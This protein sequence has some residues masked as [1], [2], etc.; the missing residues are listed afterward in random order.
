MSRAFDSLLIANRGEIACR[1]IAAAR[2]R[3]LRTIAVYS[4]ADAQAR[5]VAMADE[6]VRIGPAAAALSYLS[7]D[8]LLSAARTSGA[9]AVHPGYGFL[10]ENA[11][12]AG[13]CEAGG[14]VFVGPSAS[15]IAAMGNKAAAKRLMLDAGV[16]CVPGYQ[17]AAQD[18]ATL[19]GKAHRIGFP[20]MVK[21]AAGGGGRGMRLVGAADGLA[22]AIASARSEA[23]A[24]FGSAELILERAIVGA[25]HVE[26]QVMADLAG[27]TIHLGERDCSLQ[28]RHQKV[29]EEAPSPA[30]NAA[31]R[32]RM[33]EAATA[34]A[35]AIRYVGAG[36]VEFLLGDDNDFYFLEMNTRIQVEHPVTEMVTG[37]DLVGMQIDIAMGK[38]LG[39]DQGDVV[40]DGHAIEARLYAEDPASGF[41]PQTGR[42][43][44]WYPPEGE[45]VRTDHGLLPGAIVGA[46]YDPMLA[47]IV[48]HGRDREEACA[49]LIVALKAT[50]LLGVQT[51]KGFLI[52]CLEHPI[53]AAGEVTTDFLE[54][55]GS[56]LAALPDRREALAAAAVLLASG[57]RSD[58]LAGWSSTGMQRSLMTLR[59]GERDLAVAVSRRGESW[60]IEAGGERDELDG[61]RVSGEE[62]TLVRGGRAL[63]F[64]TASDGDVVHVDDGRHVHRFEDLTYR[65]AERDEVARDG[66]VRAPMNGRI[67]AV[68]VE[69]GDAVV[70]DTVLVV[71]EAMKMEQ[72]LR[73]GFDGVVDTVSV[74]V[75]EQV[76]TRQMLVTLIPAGSGAVS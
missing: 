49:R 62:V 75:G 70:K 38:P 8:A 23:L 1:V 21:A 74:S 45:G 47:K 41:L 13:A 15:A 10:S 25:R 40:L 29:I 11:A 4:D 18:D 36:T 60:T 19:T 20:L 26:I 17:G 9:Q 64:A 55:E 42:I 5:H 12:F 57:G 69:A 44:D 46:D 2:T 7:M 56:A 28:R 43:F 24:A 3:G 52:D 61:A 50:R 51:N 59:N 67:T 30:V 63:R 68:H 65:P 32:E 53:F 33:G 6:A 73:A 39:L 48:A 54:G 34:A 72:S 66:A 14:L 31:I 76:A 35:R 37:L 22:D 16:P 58:E 71:L 27:A